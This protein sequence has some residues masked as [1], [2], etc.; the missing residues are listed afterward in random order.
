M[1]CF[2]SSHFA[3][4]QPPLQLTISAYAVHASINT[5]LSTTSTITPHGDLSN[6][7][8]APSSCTSA[9]C[10]AAT[11]VAVVAA[12]VTWTVGREEGA[13]VGTLVGIV[14]IK[15]VGAAVGA[16]VGAVGA[17]VGESQAQGSN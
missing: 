7:G 15:C 2:S 14:V 17:A 3:V 5:T 4:W 10:T 11:T 8:V 13:A 12:V 16:T 1:R 6:H 9:V